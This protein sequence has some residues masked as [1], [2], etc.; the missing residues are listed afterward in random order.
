MRQLL[1]NLSIKLQ[2]VVPVFI[3]MLLLIIGITYST[4]TLKD[5]FHDVSK[6]TQDL[7]RHKE[8]VIKIIDNTYGMRIK[9]IYGL[10]RAQDVAELKSS[11]QEKQAQNNQYLTSLNDVSELSPQVDTLRGAMNEYVNYSIETMIPLLQ[12]KHNNTTDAAFD[13]RYEQASALYRKE[14]QDMV[15]AINALST[16]LNNIALENMERNGQ[17]HSAVMQSSIIGLIVILILAAISSWILAGVIV[18]PIRQL[19]QTMRNVA[20]GNLLEKTEVHGNNEIA[21]LSR[22]VNITIEQLRNT[23]GS[24]VRISTDVASA[25]TEL[26]A[27]MTQSTVNSDQERQEVEQVASAVNQLEGAATTVTHNAHQADQAAQQAKELTIQSLSMFEQS[28]RANGKMV[29]QLSVAADVVNSLKVQS[30][31]I[32]QVIEVIQGISEQTNL[33]ALNAAIEAARAG[34]TG[35]GF[36]VVAD[37]VRM[38][39]AR[40]QDST[41]EIQAIIEE[42]QSQSGA[43]NDSVMSSLN[44]LQDNQDLATQLSQ[45]LD[46]INQSIQDLSVMNTEVASAA[47]EQ[48]QV[49]GDINRNLSNMYELVN[50]NVTGITQ[51]AA[52]SQ[53]LSSLAEQ[54]KQELSYFKV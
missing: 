38:L 47:E 7:I 8:E 40:T 31:K 49:T 54:Q 44:T 6:S 14:G 20:S 39:A 25:A 9:A 27:V 41:K 1:S 11:L 43:A 15:A 32:G 45:S 35:R 30:E 3:T 21:D 42:L 37:E 4:S 36:A 33:L 17:R 50:Q 12:F 53:E 16:K 23:V 26:A 19:Q 52:A 13:Q 5:A 22:D 51:S 2:V 10:F 34:E 24:L 46:S 29:D 48:S 18:K 28:H